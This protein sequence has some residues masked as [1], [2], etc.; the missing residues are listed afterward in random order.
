M[1]PVFTV[2][3][4]AAGKIPVFVSILPQ[5]YFLEKIGGDRI[6]VEVMVPPGASPATYE[7]KPKQ[8]AAL[9]GCTLYFAIGVPFETAWLPKIAATN[10]RLRIVHTDTGIKKRTMTSDHES[11]DQPTPHSGFKDPHIWL[12]PPLVKIQ[13]R[14]IRN[15]LVEMNSDNRLFYKSNFKMFIDEIDALDV[16]IR[17][18]LSG[19][20]GSA[21]MVFHPS[22]GYF[23]DAYGLKQI[24]IEIEGKN[25][26]PAQLTSLIS[27][28]RGNGIKVI[29]VQPQ[30]SSQSAQVVA[31]AIGATVVP[32]DPLALDWPENLRKQASAIAAAA[33]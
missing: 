18:I 7:P 26:K 12:S 20:A 32:A 28:A 9:A 19:K 5:K 23:A 33:K 24:P 14:T 25:P 31:G 11:L 15:A 17:A 8:M 1:S 2:T 10:S 27:F 22:W 6:A 3:A 29:F 21:F 30:F 16:E 13:A 4:G